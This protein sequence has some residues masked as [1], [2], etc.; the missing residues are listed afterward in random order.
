MFGKR[1]IADNVASNVLHVVAPTVFCLL[2]FCRLWH[3][4]IR[5]HWIVFVYVS[6]A[7][8]LRWNDRLAWEQVVSGATANP[9]RAS[10]GFEAGV[11]A[12]LSATLVVVAI[13][14]SGYRKRRWA[15]PSA[16]HKMAIACFLANMRSVWCLASLTDTILGRIQ[17][18]V[19][20]TLLWMHLPG[21]HLVLVT[22]SRK[23]QG[24]GFLIYI[25]IILY[26][27]SDIQCVYG[28]S[29][30]TSYKGGI[31]ECLEVDIQLAFTVAVA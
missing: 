12:L 17:G 11:H 20:S 10:T 8:L 3:L 21:E 31:H 5:R 23:H 15:G 7:K 25:Y 14:S 1:F 2:E 19:S 29:I 30:F 24:I 26:L 28:Q 9:W 18:G 4:L 16:Q 6:C 22:A 13:W 27:I